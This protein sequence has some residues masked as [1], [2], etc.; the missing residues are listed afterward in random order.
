MV[1]GGDSC[2]KSREFESWCRILDGND[3]FHID[4]L[5]NLYCLFEKTKNKLKEAGVGPLKKY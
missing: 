5:Q 1:M 3:S 4:L 2:S